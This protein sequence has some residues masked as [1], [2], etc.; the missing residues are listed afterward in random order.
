M[1]W[2]FWKLGNGSIRST[3][4][5]PRRPGAR[6]TLAAAVVVTRPARCRSESS[7]HRDHSLSEH[8][9]C[10]PAAT[11]SRKPG[12]GAPHQEP[13]ALERAGHGGARQQTSG[14]HW[15][16]HFDL[17]LGRHALR[18]GFNHFLRA[19]TEDGDRDIVYFQGHAA[20]GIYARAFL[21]GRIPTPEAGELPPRTETRRRPLFLSAPLA[22]ARF[23]GVPHRLDGTGPDPGDLSRALHHVSGKSWPEE[24][25]RAE[26]SGPSS[27]TAKWTNPNRSAPSRWLRASVSTI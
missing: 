22:D 20:P 13:G 19:Q 8:D 15:R 24:L 18:S 5:F 17:R 12:N 10:G 27:A 9:S 16:T 6:R 21:E 11:L 14:R 2:K 7:F 25:Q 23:L 1:D 3:M 26:K 4:C